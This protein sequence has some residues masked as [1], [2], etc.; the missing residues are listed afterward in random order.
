SPRGGDLVPYTLAEAT[1]SPV[2]PTN[3]FDRHTTVDG[4]FG[5]DIG[6]GITSKLTLNATINP[7]FGQVEGDPSEVNLTGVETFLHERRPFFVEGGDIFRYTLGAD[8]LGQEQL[9][10]S[11]RIGRAPQLDDPAN[12]IA[13]DRPDV[14]RILGAA[15]LSGKAGPWTIGGLY[16]MTG[17]ERAR[18]VSGDGIRA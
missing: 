13:V 6:L 14:T 10:Y 16:A 15:K 5:A 2:D 9:F 4:A 11:R 17:A 12:A 7:D 18:F 8:L 1:R 3:P